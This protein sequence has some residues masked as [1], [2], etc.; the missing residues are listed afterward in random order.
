VKIWSAENGREIPG[1]PA[2]PDSA[3]VD[4]A[5]SPDGTRLATG[6]FSG[7]TKV[8]RI[9]ERSD[10]G[11]TGTVGLEELFTLIGHT[12]GVYGVAF[13]P[14]DTRLVTASEDGAANVWDANN[15]QELIT[16][17]VQPQ[18]L[19]DVA[20][21]PDGKYLATAGRDGAVRLFVLDTDELIALV[22]SRVTR[23]LTDEECQRYLHLDSCP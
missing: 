14:D 5:F 7:M 2:H 12:T 17:S 19:L 9:S 8:W 15:G 3:V 22:Q 23:S 10:T 13:S 11:E 20:I 21:T 16:L 6:A 1:L 4:L 18:G